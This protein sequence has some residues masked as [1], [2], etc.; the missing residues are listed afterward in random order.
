[1]KEYRRAPCDEHGNLTDV[2]KCR[3]LECEGGKG[4]AG[5]GMCSFRGD[6]GNPKC[7]K[8]IQLCWDESDVDTQAG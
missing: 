1:M 8:F 7:G 4:L 5:N 2:V 6:W 3:W